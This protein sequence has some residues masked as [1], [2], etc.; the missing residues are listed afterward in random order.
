[1]QSFCQWTHR[2]PVP[3]AHEY[4]KRGNIDN[5]ILFDVWYLNIQFYDYQEHDTKL[6]VK[7]NLEEKTISSL[8]LVLPF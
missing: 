3:Y 7:G 6:G 8:R 1:M 2:M 5:I 4:H